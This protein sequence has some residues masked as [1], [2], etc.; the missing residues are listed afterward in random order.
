M[1]GEEQ[2]H[3]VYEEYITSKEETEAPIYNMILEMEAIELHRLAKQIENKGGLVL[4]ASTDEIT[5]MFADD[6]IPFELE[7]NPD[8]PDK[9]NL[10]GFY[11]DAAKMHPKYKLDTTK[12]GER[13]KVEKLPGWARRDTYE[14][15]ETVWNIQGDVE[16]NDFTPLIEMVLD[17]EKSCHIDGMAGTGKSTFVMKLKEEMNKRGKTHMTL[18]P[19][20]KA[21]RIVDGRTIHSFVASCCTRKALDEV[22]VDY[23]FV[24]EI[25]MVPEM[26]YKFFLTMKRMKSNI[27]FIIAGDMGQLEPVNDRVKN[28]NYKNSTAL[29]ELCEGNRV[30]L[31]KWRRGTNDGLYEACKNPGQVKESQFKQEWTTRHIAFTHKTRMWV[32]ERMMEKA[33]DKARKNKSTVAELEALEYDGHSQKVKLCAGT[34]IIAR[35]NE[36]DLGLFNNESYV[37]KQIKSK[38]EMIQIQE[39]DGDRKLEIPFKDFQRLFYPAYCITV[40]ASQ[41]S[42]FNHKYTIHEWSRFSARMKYVALS[43][44][45]LF[46]N[47]C[48][49]RSF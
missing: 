13:L 16:D 32:N 29:N 3:Q 39:E 6:V 45:T 11:Y 20:N 17:S 41:G 4:D 23:V 47:I 14:H 10:K 9:P 43:R 40:H 5:C 8:K 33:Y 49:W 42:T 21:C 30:Q 48:T 46:E 35:V 15:K 44:S 25:S 34:P 36:K 19:T 24:D 7:E 1:I 26:F 37:I 2:Y 31:E 28:C 38:S 27:R 22:A 18:A 12:E